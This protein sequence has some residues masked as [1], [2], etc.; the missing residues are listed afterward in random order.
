MVPSLMGLFLLAGAFVPT[1]LALPQDLPG[2]GVNC[3][4][5]TYGSREECQSNFSYACCAG[6][7]C[8]QSSPGAWQVCVNRGGSMYQKEPVDSGED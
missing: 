7:I 1:G 8:Y 2:Q 4:A 3:M 6:R 5:G